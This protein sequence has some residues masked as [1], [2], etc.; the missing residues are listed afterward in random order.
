MNQAT[1]APPVVEKKSGLTP[2]TG[3]TTCRTTSGKVPAPLL[4]ANEND[5]EGNSAIRHD[6]QE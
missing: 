4:S 1:Q 6:D 3:A 2:A 5:D